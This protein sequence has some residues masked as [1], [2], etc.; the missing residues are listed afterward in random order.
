VVIGVKAALYPAM[1]YRWSTSS[2][3]V[4][5]CRRIG[6]SVWNPSRT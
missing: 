3:V 1:K 6:S 5:R 2:N 4:G